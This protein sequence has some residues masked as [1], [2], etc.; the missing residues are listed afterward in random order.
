MRFSLSW[1]IF[2]DLLSS[3]DKNSSK[4]VFWICYFIS[5]AIR[6]IFQEIVLP[7]VPCNDD[8][9]VWLRKFEAFFELKVYW[10]T[11]RVI[12]IIDSSS[13]NSSFPDDIL[14][15]RWSRIDHSSA[16]GSYHTHYR[17]KVLSIFSH[18]YGL[19]T[20]TFIREE[21]IFFLVSPSI[22]PWLVCS[23][24]HTYPSFFI[25]IFW[26]ECIVHAVRSSKFYISFGNISISKC[27]F[28][29]KCNMWYLNILSY[30]SHRVREKIRIITISYFEHIN[31]CSGD[32]RNI[33][34]QISVHWSL[35]EKIWWFLSDTR[36]SESCSASDS[37]DFSWSQRFF[38]KITSKM[39][40][41]KWI[42]F[43]SRKCAICRLNTIFCY[44]SRNRF[45]SRFENPWIHEWVYH[46][47]I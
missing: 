21:K 11:R 13:D 42:S 1:L 7:R 39:T 41:K 29:S 44:W 5:L 26:L 10:R 46:R 40:S 24:T 23:P 27:T 15:I 17:F 45:R 34:L 12:C 30:W 25:K 38:G 3:W 35:F 8:L 14:Y 32:I 4:S 19:Y 6:I 22:C 43:H 37:S 28:N 16:F 2:G 18:Y 33:C 20:I 31:M 9:Q 36:Y 47:K